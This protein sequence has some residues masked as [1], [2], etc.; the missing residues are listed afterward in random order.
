VPLPFVTVI[1]D[2]LL[3]ALEEQVVAVVSVNAPLTP[4]AAAA[5]LSGSMLNVQGTVNE[6]EFDGLLA[7]DPPGPI[8]VTRA[9]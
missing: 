1:H 7:A 2:A 4:V 6:K 5:T 3:V 9:S 8:A